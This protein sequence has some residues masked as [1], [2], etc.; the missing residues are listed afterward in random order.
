MARTFKVPDGT[1]IGRDFYVTVVDGGRTGYLLGPF[2]THGEA[3]AN[4]ERGKALAVKHN[5]RA[6]FGEYAYG[7]ASAPHGTNILTVFGR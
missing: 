6:C 7:T 4:V 5:T 1:G 2:A 3:L